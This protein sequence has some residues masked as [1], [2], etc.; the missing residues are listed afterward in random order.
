[1]KSFVLML[2]MAGM[3][4]PGGAAARPLTADSG[5]PVTFFAKEWGDVASTFHPRKDRN[6]VF[7]A[8]SLKQA[9]NWAWF[10]SIPYNPASDYDFSKYSVLAVFYK[11]HSAGFEPI[12]ESVQESAA[13]DLSAKIT[14]G[15]YNAAFCATPPPDPAHPWGLYIVIKI[16]K[17]SLVTRPKTLHVTTAFA[18]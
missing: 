7:Y 13:G 1:M 5:K 9:K 16:D 11:G 2:V 17:R 4:V 15:C 18:T 12:V 14:M 10:T 3:L 8:A 6:R